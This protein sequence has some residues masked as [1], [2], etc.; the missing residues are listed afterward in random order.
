MAP[1]LMGR[2]QI[3]SLLGAAGAAAIITGCSGGGSDTSSDTSTDTGTDTGSDS[4]SGTDS[5]SGDSGVDSCVVDPT[6]TNG[7][8][9]ADG[10]NSVSGS[11]VNV[12]TQS[13]VVRSDIRSSFGSYSGTADGVPVTLKITLVN[14]NDGC[15]PLEGYVIYIWHCT[16]EGEYSLYS[17]SIRDTNY[18]RGVQEADEN[19]QVT[20]TTIF[21]GCYSGRWPHIH[22]E[23]YASLDEATHYNNRE[24]VSQMAMPSDVCSTLYNNVSLYSASVSNFN[25]ISISSDNVFGDNSSAEISAQTPTVDSGNYSDGYVMSIVVGLDA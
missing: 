2:R 25:R 7:P 1:R 5:G 8:Y 3:L 21:P 4:G 14:V 20:F 18:L 6:E 13:G 11:T 15:A 10:S 23:V 24:L 9:P 17:T 16:A 12:L 19:G 22:F